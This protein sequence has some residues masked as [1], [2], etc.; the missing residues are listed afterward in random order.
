MDALP[1]SDKCASEAFQTMNLGIFGR[2]YRCE[3]CGAKFDSQEKLT[4]HTKTHIQQP[5]PVTQ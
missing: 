1:G 5:M 2:K 3:T 4:E